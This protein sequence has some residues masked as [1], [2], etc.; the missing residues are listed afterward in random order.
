MMTMFLKYVKYLPEVQ[1]LQTTA[2]ANI[3]PWATKAR[4]M[5]GT[6]GFQPEK[7]SNKLSKYWDRDAFK[8][9]DLLSASNSFAHRNA[10]RAQVP[11]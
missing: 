2:R 11:F 5:P 9:C 10:D 3:V 7:F 6:V 1:Y 8:S 4:I